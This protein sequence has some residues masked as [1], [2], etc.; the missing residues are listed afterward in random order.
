MNLSDTIAVIYDGQIKCT[1]NHG[2][3]TQNQ[4]GLLMGGGG[5]DGK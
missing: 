2:E 1:F 3:A 5:T 4:I